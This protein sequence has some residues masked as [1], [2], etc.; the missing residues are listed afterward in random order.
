MGPKTPL[1]SVAVAVT[2]NGLP[3]V[4]LVTGAW[5]KTGGSLSSGPAGTASGAGAGAGAGAGEGTAPS[6][7]LRV[8]SSMSLG[9]AG[10]G[11]GGG[12]AGCVVVPFLLFFLVEVLSVVFFLAGFFSPGA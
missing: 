1:R 5:F 6:S 11:A 10:T 2:V 9:A 3:L 7:A 4:A 8:S 12:G